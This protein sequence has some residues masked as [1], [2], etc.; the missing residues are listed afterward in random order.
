MRYLA[1]A[2][3]LLLALCIYAPVS[4]VA[5]MH[6]TGL[7]GAESYEGEP[8]YIDGLE[9]DQRKSQPERRIDLSH[10]WATILCRH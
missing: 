5:L 1:S 7:S 8:V 3:I 6:V 9:C 10:A 2:I 4:P